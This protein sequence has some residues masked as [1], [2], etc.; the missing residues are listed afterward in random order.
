ML[1]NLEMLGMAEAKKQIQVGG[2]SITPRNFLVKVIPSPLETAHLMTGKGCA[3]AW[4]TGVKDGVDRSVYVYNIADNQECVKRLGTNSVVAQTAVGPV[5]MLELVATG[6]W[7]GKGVCTPGMFNPDPFVKLMK[8][9]GFPAG[10][11]EK[12]STY[13]SR[14]DVEKMYQ[15]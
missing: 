1:K 9:Y 5:A 6:E 13:S 12:P 8:K 10:V 2:A 3:G 14:L 7:K 4:V 15:E 11:Q